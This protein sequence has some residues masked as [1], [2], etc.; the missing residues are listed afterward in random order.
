MPPLAPPA[1][2]G[3]AQVEDAEV[4]EPEYNP[5]RVFI[6]LE[7][8]ERHGFTGGCRRCTLMREGRRCQGVKHRDA[9]R[10]RVEQ[11]LRDAGDPRLDRAEQRVMDELGRRAE[12]V[13]AAAPP[14]PGGVEVPLSRV[15]LP[16]RNPGV[17]VPLSRVEPPPGAG[18]D[19]APLAVHERFG[20]DGSAEYPAESRFDA[21]GD[22][23]MRLGPG[24]VAELYSPPRV[25]AT[26]P[27]LG[28][29]AGSTFDLH[30]DEAGVAWDFTRPSDRKRAWDRLRAEEPFL[31]VGSP[32]CTMFSRLQL[33][34]NARKMGKIEWER[35]RREA[36]V[37]LIFA[38]AVYRLQV[39]G[40]RHFLHEHPAGATSWS[41]PAVVRLRARHGVDAVVSHMCEFGMETTSAGDGRRAAARKP[42]RF[43]SSS[44]A[45]LEALSR[46]C[47]GDHAHAPLLGG[48]RAKDAAVYPP[49]LCHAIALGAAE[50]LRRDARAHC[51][52]GVALPAHPRAV[53]GDRAAPPSTE[54]HCEE[55]QCRVGNEEDELAAWPA[56]QTFDEITG[57]VLPP[58]LVKQARAEEI[59]FMLDWG[60]WERAPIAECWRDTGKAPVGSKWVD[61]NKGD[62]TKPLIRSRFVVKE[63][64][65]YKSDDFFAATP[66]LESFRLL[67]SLAASDAGDT[68]IEVLDA[69]KAHLHAFAERTVFTQLPPEE[70]APGYCA[71]L[72]RC[73]YGTRDAPKR[74]EAFLAEQLVA[75]GFANLGPRAARRPAA[76]TTRRW[77]CAV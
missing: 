20:G 69:R 77:E 63:I 62:A 74:W 19:A 56:K 24:K 3:G 59:K 33:N 15:E 66:P 71:R 75:L 67:L 52:A 42:T 6:R 73:L 31:V 44:P 25:T 17:E 13:E 16:P 34:L 64:A 28:L 14:P 18:A 29:A 35:R 41:H 43:M 7:D 4:R 8:L 53:R 37:L 22:A 12:G 9:C 55:A 36:E 40:G 2:A 51:I 47:R 50:Q 11:A 45:I 27:K 39:Q 72:V 68:K 23:V 61:V 49:G 60:V 26:L 57:A 54:V 30:A 58:E 32:P 70:M 48:T 21:N 5:H 65:T 10:D 38:V 76:S 1:A 46:K